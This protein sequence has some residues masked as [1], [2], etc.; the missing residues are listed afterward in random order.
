MLDAS[1]TNVECPDY[2]SSDNYFVI[3]NGQKTSSK[4]VY[5]CDSKFTSNID[6]IDCRLLIFSCTFD[7]IKNDGILMS[8]IYLTYN[9][10]TLSDKEPNII[11]KCNFT[12]CITSQGAIYIN[13]ENS[14]SNFTITDCLFENNQATSDYGG[15]IQ[16]DVVYGII[17]NC[18][19]INNLALNGAH[20]ALVNDAYLETEK[21]LIIRNNYFLLEES[22]QK[23]TSLIYF[24]TK[25]AITIVNNT[26]DNYYKGSDYYLIRF[27]RNPLNYE[28]ADNCLTPYIETN[29]IRTGTFTI[30]V[31]N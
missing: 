6:S 27:Y 20:I 1:N 17:E 31:D 24:S 14:F 8:A 30:D 10:N 21:K 7:E 13:G 19:F 3:T 16:L 22:S 2:S 26:F 15:G 18:K 4:T 11:S 23:I 29:I 25:Q 5:S 28:I 9:L 12:K